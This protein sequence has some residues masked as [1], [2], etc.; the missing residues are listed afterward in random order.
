MC[1][2]FDVSVPSHRLAKM[3]RGVAVVVSDMTG[4][5]WSRTP[6]LDFRLGLDSYN[7]DAEEHHR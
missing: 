5:L 7:L 1:C 2:R 6:L 4:D 3:V